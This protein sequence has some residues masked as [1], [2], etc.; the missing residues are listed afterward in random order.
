[1]CFFSLLST[2]NWWYF[3]ESPSVFRIFLIDNTS[4]THDENSTANTTDMDKN[5]S[6]H[7]HTQKQKLKSAY[8]LGTTNRQMSVHLNTQFIPLILQFSLYYFYAFS[9][10]FNRS[11]SLSRFRVSSIFSLYFVI[12][13]HFLFY[14]AF[15]FRVSRYLGPYHMELNFVSKKLFKCVYSLECRFFRLSVRNNQQQHQHQEWCHR[16]PNTKQAIHKIVAIAKI[17]NLH[18]I[19]TFFMY[20]MPIL[21]AIF[22]LLLYLFAC[23]F[24]LLLL[25][26]LLSVTVV[27]VEVVAVIF[28]RFFSTLGN[29]VMWSVRR[30]T[31]AFSI[32]TCERRIRNLNNSNS[33]QTN[34]RL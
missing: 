22:R 4:C 17:F 1:M 11:L 34:I 24:R 7:T 6:T 15:S 2:N 19:S 27:V 16:V 18:F 10:S 8:H 28:E 9:L 29:H 12:C 23:C 33:N 14:L 13:L 31:S 3:E 32:N 26:L 25:L 21:W 5:L 30:R 20:L